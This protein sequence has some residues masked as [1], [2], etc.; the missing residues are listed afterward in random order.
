M[1]LVSFILFSLPFSARFKLYSNISH[2]MRWTLASGKKKRY[3]SFI[4]AVDEDD[5]DDEENQIK[6]CISFVF[7]YPHGPH[8]LG[9]LHKM[10]IF[11]YTFSFFFSSKINA[12]IQSYWIV[13]AQAHHLFPVTLI[14]R[15]YFFC[16]ILYAT[17]IFFSICLLFC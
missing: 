4:G 8:V 3:K 17:L 10:S 1:C 6:F 13:H 9:L 2:W 5:G 7:I 15:M 14:I 12:M 16:F 11:Y